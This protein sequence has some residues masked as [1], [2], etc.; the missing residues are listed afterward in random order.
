[1]TGELSAVFDRKDVGSSGLSEVS[2]L[3]VA[4]IEGYIEVDAGSEGTTVAAG[5]IRGR[6]ET[7]PEGNLRIFRCLLADLAS[8]SASWGRPHDV[9]PK[10]PLDL[11]EVGLDADD[12]EERKDPAVLDLLSKD[13]E[14]L[15]CAL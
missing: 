5:R 3:A 7:E 1:M 14:C 10:E 9:G 4:S 8:T 11:N 15:D 2:R 6:S 12:C 13:P